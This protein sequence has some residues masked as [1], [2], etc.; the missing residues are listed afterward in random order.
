LLAVACA[1]FP[2]AW[3]LLA[4]AAANPPAKLS[5]PPTTRLELAAAKPLVPGGETFAA[6]FFRALSLAALW[7]AFEWVQSWF[8]TGFPWNQLAVTQWRHVMLISV[9]RLT[10]VYG[11]S[12][13][14]L[15]VNVAVATVLAARLATMPGNARRPLPGAAVCAMLLLAALLFHWL[16]TPPP[17]PPDAT[18][19][20]VGVQGNIPQCRVY[21]DAQLEE[22]IDVYRSLS[23][24]AAET[25]D[26]DLFVWPESALPA[27]VL[28]ERRSFAM[29]AEVLSK[30]GGKLLVGSINIVPPP[31][32][33]DGPERYYNSALLFGRQGRLLQVYDKVHLVP[34]G[35]YVPF[36]SHLPWLVDL[37]G[38]GRDLSPGSEYTLFSLPGGI[39]AGVNICFEDAFPGISREFTRRGADLL[40]TITNDAWYVESSGSRQHMLH[41]VFRAVENGRP[42]FRSGNNSDTC[43]ITPRG[44]IQGLLHDPVTG[45]RFVRGYK[46]YDIP[47]ATDAPLTFYTRFGDVFAK[48]CAL[49]SLSLALCLLWLWYR[50][51]QILRDRIDDNAEK[52]E[53]AKTPADP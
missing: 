49:Y 44:R 53:P 38:M 29:L 32:G 11:L 17:P 13:A 21:N 37:I 40:M 4:A 50:R 51:K 20:V 23:L 24:A 52:R 15:A 7:V 48:L 26:V 10:G 3:Y 42:L 41:A 47:V 33:S 12:F 36:S 9:A 2:A 14:I 28:W 5:T 22:A 46:S 25:P 43:V 18:L 34:F 27:P 30:L 19:R 8:L 31:E 35:E 16:A 45:E 1:G 39:E 6:S